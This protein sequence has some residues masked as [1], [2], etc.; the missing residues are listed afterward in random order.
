MIKETEKLNN[1]LSMVNPPIKKLFYEGNLDL[2]NDKTL[3][4]SVIGARKCSP[5]GIQAT[6]YIIDLLNGFENI[7]IVSRMAY[8]VEGLAHTIAMKNNIKSIGVPM[9][10]IS[11]DHFYPRTHIDL[12][13]E[14]LEKGGLIINEFETNTR[15]SL[16]TAPIANRLISSMAHITLVVEV[17]PNSDA[18]DKVKTAIDLGRTVIAVPSNIFSRTSGSNLILAKFKDAIAFTDADAFMKIIAEVAEK[19]NIKI[20]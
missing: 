1:N 4:I 17:D 12:K 18:I 15:A 13:H 2:L 10:G 7:T 11:D 9:S 6:E 8:G 3:C 5:Y 19:N 16:W 14:V 20:N